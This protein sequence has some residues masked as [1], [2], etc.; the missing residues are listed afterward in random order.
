MH[1]KMIKMVVLFGFIGANCLLFSS[2]VV[3]EY[4]N[5]REP[6]SFGKSCDLGKSYPGACGAQGYCLDFNN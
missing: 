4:T 2:S 1:K 3:A 6:N 5:C